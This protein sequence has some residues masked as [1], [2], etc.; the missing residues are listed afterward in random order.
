LSTLPASITC[1]TGPPC[2]PQSNIGLLSGPVNG[3]GGNLKGIELTASLRPTLISDA[4]RQLR[5]ILSI[6]QTDSN[7]TVQD[8]ADQL[9]SGNNLATYRCRTVQTVVERDFYYENA[10]FS[11]RISTRARSK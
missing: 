4:L 6:A 1:P 11:T 10:G 9:I 2:P 7:I 5:Y 3:Q 8:A